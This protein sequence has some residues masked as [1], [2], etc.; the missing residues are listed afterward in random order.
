MHACNPPRRRAVGGFTVL[1]LMIV[2]MVVAILGLIAYPS[3]ERLVRKSYRS[4]GRELI[5]GL[6]QFAERYYTLNARYPSSA[7]FGAANLK[8]QHGHYL[9]T[10]TVGAGPPATYTIVAV[11]QGRQIRDECGSLGLDN[12]GAHTATGPAGAAACW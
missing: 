9:A 2:V 12:L 1:E 4:D 11:P 5:T 3:F 10:Y 6:A 7:D 8:S